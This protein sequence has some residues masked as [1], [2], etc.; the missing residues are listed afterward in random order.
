MP[1]TAIGQIDFARTI[2]SPGRKVDKQAACSLFKFMNL[3]SAKQSSPELEHATI[4]SQLFTKNEEICEKFCAEISNDIPR[5]RP[6]NAIFESGLIITPSS[7]EF[8]YLTSAIE[9]SKI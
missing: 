8:L 7:L 2:T 1:L 5:E 9:S 3:E 4:V 6:I